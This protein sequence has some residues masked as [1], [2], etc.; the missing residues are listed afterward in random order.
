VISESMTMASES[1]RMI[2]E[3][4]PTFIVPDDVA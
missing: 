4:A 2:G 1:V 3:L